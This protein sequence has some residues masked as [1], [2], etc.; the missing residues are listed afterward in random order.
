[1]VVQR[2]VIIVDDEYLAREELAA[3]LETQ[4]L[5][6][7]IIGKLESTAKAWELLS[8]DDSIE[9]IFLDIDIHTETRRSGLDFALKLQRLAV[10]PWIIFITGEREHAVEAYQSFPV[11][12]LLKPVDNL[13]LE[14]ALNWVRSH[15]PAQNLV[16]RLA[17]RHRIEGEDQEKTTCT[18]YVEL[19]EI[20]YI[21]KNNGVNSIR[22][23]LVN[24]DVLDGV[25]STLAEWKSHGFFQIHRRNLVNIK[26]IRREMPR[27]GENTVYKLLFK[28]SP[29]ELDIGPDYLPLLHE[30][31]KKG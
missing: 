19:D 13:S 30:E 20:L 2:R 31:L 12:F 28:N 10:K 1:M 17:I 5:D 3:M 6:F 29:V 15:R 22:V 16:R 4:H 7:A 25:N 23:G 21:Q 27:I 8:A 9:G 24:G 11:S 26:H 18:D 14:R